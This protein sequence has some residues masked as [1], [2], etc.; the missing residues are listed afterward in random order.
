MKQ[1]YYCVT[2]IWSENSKLT[3]LLLGDSMSQAAHKGMQQLVRKNTDVT[4][5]VELTMTQMRANKP[6]KLRV[7][8][9]PT[10]ALAS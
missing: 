6:I 9:S 1:Q 3:T 5:P 8:S 4:Y 7:S 2:A 10:F